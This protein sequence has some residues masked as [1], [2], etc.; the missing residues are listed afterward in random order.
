MSHFGCCDGIAMVYTTN[1]SLY[2]T[3]DIVEFHP[4]NLPNPLP[5]RGHANQVYMVYTSEAP[6]NII[7]F[8]PFAGV[9]LL[10]TYSRDS[11]IRQTY[12][13]AGECACDII[14]RPLAI[15]FSQRRK[16]PISALVSNCYSY[17]KREKLLE[18]M[19]SKIPIHSMGTCLHNY[20]LSNK[21]SLLDQL[22]Q[23]LYAFSVENA[24]CQDYITEK[25]Y[26]AYQSYAVPIVFSRGTYPGYEDV[27]P[28]RNSYVDLGSFDSI[29]LAIQFLRETAKSE[30]A[31]ARHH[32]FRGQ[33]RSS[34]KL[35]DT[36]KEVCRETVG[37]IRQYCSVAK[38]ILS[39][40]ML[41]HVLNRTM[42]YYNETSRQMCMPEGVMQLAVPLNRTGT[43]PPPS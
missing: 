43:A 26:R 15:R 4:R 40:S 28:S 7:D 11:D 14:L 18:Y 3:A 35:G 32:E 10:R 12:F 22:Q 16:T 38:R 41:P 25:F 29:D 34:N 6:Y 21:T 8:A 39:V 31:Y 17:G 37:D 36:F 24:I 5:P 23:Y 13:A 9:N 19:M 1:R 42:K 33:P 27:A 20:D 30:T 2:S